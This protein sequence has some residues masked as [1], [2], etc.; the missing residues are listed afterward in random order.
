MIGKRSIEMLGKLLDFHALRH[1]VIANNIA[2]AEVPGFQ[3]KE[4]QFTKELADAIEDGDV[5]R[6]RRAGFNVHSPATD[7][8]QF[9]GSVD[10]EREMGALMKNKALFDTFGEALTFKFRM[11]RN[12]MSK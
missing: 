7:L 12:A 5:D 11:L 4:V 9:S 1:K 2:N 8:S 6:V 3:P 10:V